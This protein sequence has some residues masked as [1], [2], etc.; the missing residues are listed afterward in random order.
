MEGRRTQVGDSYQ[1]WFKYAG[2]LDTMAKNNVKA[3]QEA[4]VM[5]VSMG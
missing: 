1:N 2:N 4:A 5:R 3:M